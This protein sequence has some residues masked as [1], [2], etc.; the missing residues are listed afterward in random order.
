[1]L[2]D[3]AQAEIVNPKCWADD[4]AGREP[5]VT[6]APPAPSIDDRPPK[7][8]AGSGL[9][10]WIKCAESLGI[11]VPENP[12]RGDVIELVEQHDAAKPKD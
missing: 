9:D 5:G 10:E 11:D 12:S 7:A 3:W 8:G 1:M 2:P 4:D 6:V